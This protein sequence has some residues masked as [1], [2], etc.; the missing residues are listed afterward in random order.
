[1]KFRIPLTFSSV[2]KLKQR[3]AFFKKYIKPKKSSKLQSILNNIDV[4]LTREEY[5]SICLQ[6]SVMAFAIS[7]ILS[8]TVLVLLKIS[9][10]FLLSLA[11]SLAFSIF[12]FLIRRIYPKVYDSRKQKDIE[13]NLIPAL[14]DMLVQ[15]NSGILLFSIL[16]NI[17]SSGYGE[18]SEEFKKIVR[19]INSGRPQVDVLEETGEINS[20]LFFRRTLWQISNGMRAGSDISIVLADSIKS[21]N[22]EQF[23]QI[24]N[25]GNKLNPTIVFYMLI[26]VIVP[27]LSIT[28]LTIISSL[29][30]LPEAITTGMFLGLFFFVMLV[31]VMFLGVM[32]SIRPSLI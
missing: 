2:D 28:F 15:L 20:S 14:Q 9:S 17:S 3:S 31:Q 19:K 16:V 12:I 11:V 27:A 30:N 21:L 1:M 18:L 6:G 32:R 24:Q 10:A 23:I 25:Y 4:E 26:S 5:L 29:V 13:S 7:L 22:E 8:S